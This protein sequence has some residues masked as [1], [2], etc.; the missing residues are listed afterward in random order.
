MTSLRARSEKR[1]GF[2]AAERIRLLEDDMDTAEAVQSRIE[3]KV[4]RMTGILT[5]VL[6]TLATS[7][8]MLG[9]NIAIG[10]GR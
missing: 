7:T 6:V 1:H 4:D 10:G 3:G 9:L 2:E 5:G 8:V